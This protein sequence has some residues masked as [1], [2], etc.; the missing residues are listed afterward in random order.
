[1]EHS[2]AGDT[3]AAG[4]DKAG[5]PRPLPTHTTIMHLSVTHLEAA[6]VMH[7]L[8]CLPSRFHFPGHTFQLCLKYFV[9][10]G[11]AC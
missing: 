6:L 7:V 4:E 1:M 9:G 8:F 2:W 10:F 3:P 5:P 11:T